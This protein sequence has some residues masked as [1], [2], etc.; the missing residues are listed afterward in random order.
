MPINP[1]LL[2]MLA[3]QT[4]RRPDPAKAFASS[5]M[6]SLEPALQKIILGKIEEERAIRQSAREIVEKSI[7]DQTQVVVPEGAQYLDFQKMLRHP[8]TVATKPKPMNLLFRQNNTATGEV[9]SET[10]PGRGIAQVFQTNYD[11]TKLMRIDL[12]K[13][14][15]DAKKKLDTAKLNLTKDKQ[16]DDRIR[17]TT[18]AVMAQLKIYEDTKDTSSAQGYQ[19]LDTASS[20]VEDL[21]LPLLNEVPA[22]GRKQIY[23]MLMVDIPVDQRGGI[24]KA[25]PALAEN[26]WTNWI[27]GVGKQT[28]QTVAVPG[29]E[30]PVIKAYLQYRGRPNPTEQDIASFY[31]RLTTDPA[32]SK[33][34]SDF[35]STRPGK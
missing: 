6:T 19:A 9:T 28:T 4:N 27:W 23:E 26:N 32:L 5:F 33:A 10:V 8:E 18:A 2:Q 16:K 3:D 14:Q 31:N 17:N 22:A 20:T 25:N 7:A 13:L 21:L 30:Q 12:S 24:G 35:K 11:P 1:Q 34:Y 29:V 15:L